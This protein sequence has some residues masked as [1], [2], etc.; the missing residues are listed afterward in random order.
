M[1]QV[2]FV[3][4]GREFTADQHTLTSYTITRVVSGNEHKVYLELKNQAIPCFIHQQPGPWP[5]GHPFYEEKKESEVKIKH[6]Q[7]PEKAA[8]WITDKV[9][10]VAICDAGR[11]NEGVNVFYRDR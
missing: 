8:E 2:V 5:A 1:K 3:I 9:S 4:D 6:F 10:I 11:F 7:Y